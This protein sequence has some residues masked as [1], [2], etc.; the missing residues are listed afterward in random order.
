MWV[1]GNEY[2]QK[3]QPWAKLK[4]D[5]DSA[6]VS[7]RYALNLALMFAAV[8][9]PFI[10]EASARIAAA[11]AEHRAPLAWPEKITDTLKRGAAITVPAVLFAKLEDDQVAEWSRRFA[12]GTVT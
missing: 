6:G 12:G 10:P 11:V 3:A 9:Q 8:A 2:L 7:I 1:I 5:P 4:A